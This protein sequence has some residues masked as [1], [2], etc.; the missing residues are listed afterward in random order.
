M[1]VKVKCS[2][3]GNYFER[4][5]SVV[6]F[7]K[8]RGMRSYCSRKCVGK[9]NFNQLEKPP[10]GVVHP[11][12]VSHTRKN[13]LTPFRNFFRSAK[14]RQ[15]SDKGRNDGFDLSVEDLVNQWDEQGGKCP[16]TG[17]DLDIR[18]Q[19]RSAKAE[20]IKMY[21]PK[22]A[23]LDRID[24]SKPYTKDNI[25]FVSLMAQYAKNTWDGNELIEFC[26]AV[27][28]HNNPY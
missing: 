3:C 22:R 4:E 21:H 6:E 23:S 18:A 20:K 11:N 8:K 17:W 24:S 10:K 5:K 14:R 9:D 7:R 16:Y 2:H 19:S 13:S 12:L 27:V 26:E 1:N 25:Q 15:F 28:E